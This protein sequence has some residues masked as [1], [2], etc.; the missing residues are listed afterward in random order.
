MG[1]LSEDLT[2]IKNVEDTLVANKV[3]RF[4]YTDTAYT[5]NDANGV[6]TYDYDN[7]QNIPNPTTSIL[8]VNSTVLDKGY[9]AQASS[10]TRM[11]INH[12][13]GRVSYNLNK[14]NDNMSSLIATL[15]A[16]TGTAN[17]FATLDANGRIPYSQLPESAV[18][19]KGYWNASTNTPTLA[20]GTGT[21]GDEYFVDTA[22]SQDLGSGLQSF[23]VGDRVVYT[24]GIWKNIDS[25]SIKS[26][27]EITADSQGEVDLT[28]QGDLTKILS[29]DLIADYIVPI[30]SKWEF[31]S[32]TVNSGMANVYDILSYFG[33]FGDAI[34]LGHRT[35]ANNNAS[36]LLS[37]MIS[38]DGGETFSVVWS[39]SA[40]Q[41]KAIV[42]AV[43]LEDIQTYVAITI[44]KT[45]SGDSYFTTVK[46]ETCSSD[47][48]ISS[49]WTPRWTLYDHSSSPVWTY[50]KL[51]HYNDPTEGEMVI[52]AWDKDNEAGISYS[53]NGSDWTTLF[54]NGQIGATSGVGHVVGASIDEVHHTLYF[55]SARRVNGAEHNYQ[56][57][58]VVSV[59][60]GTELMLNYNPV[61]SSS[62]SPEGIMCNN[63]FVFN[64]SNQCLYVMAINI[65]KIP[66]SDFNS[67]TVL[68]E[69]YYRDS[70]SHSHI[71]GSEKTKHLC[72]YLINPNYTPS[73]TEPSAYLATEDTI[74]LDSNEM[75]IS[76]LYQAFEMNGSII[77]PSIARRTRE[78]FLFQKLLFPRYGFPSDTN[79]KFLGARQGDTIYIESTEDGTLRLYK[80]NLDICL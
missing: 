20:D 21:N 59:A 29:K 2:A 48:T 67:Y 39:A 75:Q 68:W 4:S 65:I 72:F 34:I 61:F 71:I 35:N 50:G 79:H 58:R 49:N 41:G 8:K 19:L 40:S 53:K 51:L 14:I 54:T 7:E 28:K 73:G 62:T 44:E 66:V 3:A 24:G 38:T 18:E 45:S 30:G 12:F 80:T 13:F 46:I 74:I 64:E 78:D 31:I 23:K 52:F 5:N 16:H 26:V 17:G 36:A 63:L 9:R 25:G 43:Y 57:Y 69:G 11:L 15:R 77:F 56:F 10:I 32:K 1:T 6:D 33:V 42:S 60:D 22:G 70:S 76:S 55:Y 27:C 47:P 37:T